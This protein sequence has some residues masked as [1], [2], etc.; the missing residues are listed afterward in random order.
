MIEAGN[1]HD[2][3]PAQHA[4][5]HITELLAS[6]NVRIERIVSRGHAGAPGEWYD[7]DCAEWVMLA[8][9][10]A[11]LL[12]E[13]EYQPRRLRAGDYVHIPAHRR[14][15]VVWTDA[16]EPTIWLAVHVR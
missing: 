9:G 10:S 6:P 12:F 8:S 11:G 3:I 7:Q 13:G 15:R 5:E 2:G 1:L 4:G 16:R 14:H